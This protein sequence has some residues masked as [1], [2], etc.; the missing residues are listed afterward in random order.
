M[1]VAQFFRINGGTTQLRGV[2]PDISLPMLTDAEDFGESSYDNALPWSQIKAADYKPTGDLTGIVPM[3]MANH[4]VRI[5][6][7]KDFQYLQK[8]IAEFNIQHKKNLISLNEADRRKEREEQE[9]R[10]KLRENDKGAD[11]KSVEAMSPAFQDDGLQSSERNL[12]VDLA[13]EKANKNAK[14]VLLDEAVHILSDEV[15]LLKANPKLSAN[16]LP[17]LNMR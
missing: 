8:D 16:V 7:D 11:K 3:L 15:G 14:D 12:D 2:A 5:S 10:V 1:T 6:K 9:A 4:D 13:I 17:K